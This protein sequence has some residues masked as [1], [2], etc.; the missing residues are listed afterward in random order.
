MSLTLVNF[1]NH[2]Y[3]LIEQNNNSPPPP[4]IIIIVIIMAVTGFLKMI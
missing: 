4:T 3:T 1:L 2:R